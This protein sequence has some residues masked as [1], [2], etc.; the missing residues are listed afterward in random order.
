MR[1]TSSSA[2]ALFI[3]RHGWWAAAHPTHNLRLPLSPLTA[4]VQYGSVERLGA[5][6]VATVGTAAF[7][8]SWVHAIRNR[9]GAT[10]NATPKRRMLIGRIMGDINANPLV[11]HDSCLPRRGPAAS[12][13]ALNAA[14]EMTAAHLLCVGCVHRQHCLA[15]LVHWRR[16]VTTRQPARPT[17]AGTPQ[18]ETQARRCASSPASDGHPIAAP[19]RIVRRGSAGELQPIVLAC[20]DLRRDAVSRQP[21]RTHS[22]EIEPPSMPSTGKAIASSGRCIPSTWRSGR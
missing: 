2:V 13:H 8:W 22:I 6:T 20:R 10:A 18:F 16:S 9:A 4:P 14:S 7:G 11:V 5:A 15:E 3:I 21:T 19:A 12:V 1:W 17:C